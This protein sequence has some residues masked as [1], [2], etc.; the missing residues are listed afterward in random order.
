M[1]AVSDNQFKG[2]MFSYLCTPQRPMQQQHSS[3][4]QESLLLTKDSLP[5]QANHSH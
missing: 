4:P 5:Q 2:I 3:D 1:M